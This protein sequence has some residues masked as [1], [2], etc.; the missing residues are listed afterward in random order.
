[1]ELF[2]DIHFGVSE[3]Y[4]A[5]QYDERLSGENYQLKFDQLITSLKLKQVFEDYVSLKY[6][7]NYFI[8]NYHS[9]AANDNNE[10]SNKKA[11]FAVAI[12]F[13]L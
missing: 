11:S 2:E 12:E 4:F 9:Q 7:L 5:G 13:F 10:S 8:R 3:V 1:H 6:N